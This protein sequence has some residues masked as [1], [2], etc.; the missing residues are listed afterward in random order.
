MG[1]DRELVDRLLEDYEKPE[2]IIGENGL[3]QQLTKAVVERA[4]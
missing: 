3:L 1:I 4:L 2:D